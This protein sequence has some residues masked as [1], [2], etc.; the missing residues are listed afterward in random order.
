MARRGGMDSGGIAGGRSSLRANGSTGHE[1]SLSSRHCERVR[2]NLLSASFRGDAKHRT[3]DAQL[4][5]GESRDSGSGAAHHPGMTE[6]VIHRARRTMTGKG[7]PPSPLSCHRACGASSA[8]RLVRSITS[9]S[10]SWIV[11]SSRTMTVESAAS[12]RAI[13]DMLSISAALCAR[14]FANSF[15]LLETEGA[16]NAGCPVHPQ[17][18]VRIVVVNMHTSIHSGGTGNIRHSPRDGVTAY[19]VLLCLRYLP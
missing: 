16:G 10:E 5:I 15:A 1:A 18:G 6:S 17:P 7:A 11:R 3:S 14:D 2:G 19:G 9:A 8:P 12:S 4:R 13:A